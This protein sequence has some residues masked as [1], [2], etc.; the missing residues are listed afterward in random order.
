M[1]SLI[2]AVDEQFGIGKNNSLLC[3]LPADLIHFKQLTM[4]KPIIM[5]RKTFESIGRPL[6]GRQNIVLSTQSMNIHGAMVMASIE[7]ALLS[8]K[9]APEIMIIGGAR[10]FQAAMPVA[11]R[12]YLTVIHQRF[13]ADVFFPHLEKTMWH[14][15]ETHQHLHDEKNPYDMTFCH[16]ERTKY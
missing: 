1:I 12:I 16:Y 4:G 6:P 15:H 9:D 7:D 13:A 10:V 14:L 3:H 5:G 11:Q 8:V 2:A